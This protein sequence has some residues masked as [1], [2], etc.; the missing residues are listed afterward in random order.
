[1]NIA[2]D[3]NFSVLAVAD[4]SCRDGDLAELGVCSFFREGCTWGSIPLSAICF[5]HARRRYSGWV[6]TF[7]RYELGRSGVVRHPRT[8]LFY[9]VITWV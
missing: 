8:A 4:C 6:V 9:R 2:A 5:R 7:R 3:D 1:M